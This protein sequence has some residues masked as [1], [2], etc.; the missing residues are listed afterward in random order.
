[1]N[2][3]I[4]AASERA[5]REVFGDI[6]DHFH[7]AASDSGSWGPLTASYSVAAHLA[8]G[9]VDLRSDDTIAISEL[10]VVWDTLAVSLGIDIPTWC[11]GGWCIVPTPWGCAVR[12]PR[13]CFF[14]ADP[15]I[16]LPLDLSGLLRSE[17]SL[18]AAPVVRHQVDPGRAS[19]MDDVDAH[20]AGVPTTWQVLLAVVSAD[21]D[22]FDIADIVGDLLEHAIDAA[23]NVLLGSAPG[24]FKD[25]VRAVF[26]SLV[27]L[28]RTILDIPDDIGEWL[29]NLLGTSLGLINVLTT[30]IANHLLGDR[31]LVMLEDPYP[32]LPSSSGL[33]PASVPVANLEVQIADDE[34]VVTATVGP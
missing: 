4:V 5:V 32:V 18:V 33:I 2:E 15:D 12:L 1:M 7:L 34:M 23:L 9:T 28:V 8:N 26:G 24:W 10:D 20:A 31:P 30:A 22:V 21:V 27:D 25:L 13:I 16:S 14:T 11:V 3:M 29:Q 17:V 6:R 19:W